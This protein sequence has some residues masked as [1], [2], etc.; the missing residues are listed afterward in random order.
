MRFLVVLPTY[1]EAPNVRPMVEAVLAADPRIDVLVVD[2][3]SPDG[4][5][6]LVEAAM[7]SEPRLSL[8][9]RPGKLG[10]GTAY[11]AGFHH[12]LEGG[13]EL[14][15]TMDCDGSHDPHYLPDLIRGAEDHDLVIGSRYV[16][17]GG[18]AHWPLHRR[19]LSKGA[20]LY[21]RALLR[22]PV[23]DC[24]SGYRC[25]RR[26]VLEA[27]DPFSVR[28]SGY[29]FLEEM[30]WRVHRA[31]FRIGETPILFEDRMLGRSKIGRAEIG[32]AMVHVLGT[33]LR[34]TPAALRA[35]RRA[36]RAR[37]A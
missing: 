30:V 34:P 32:R 21:T 8:L 11:Q 26:E 17:G 1:D 16:P 9:R 37:R 31:G 29:S 19:L 3:A 5:G 14:V 35:H 22:L 23:R 6:D 4:T 2:D 28:S 24:T 12:G 15:L 13:H 20:N 7:E 33:A 18:V 10:L 36:A 27:V 25:H